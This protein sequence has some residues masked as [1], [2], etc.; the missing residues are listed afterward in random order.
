MP[1]LFQK[2]QE[3][4]QLEADVDQYVNGA[5]SGPLASL[6]TSLPARFHGKDDAELVTLNTE[7][8][9]ELYRQTD[10]G[11]AAKQLEATVRS[12]VKDS[13]TVNPSRFLLSLQYA[14]QDMPKPSERKAFMQALT[15]GQL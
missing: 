14:L 12:W 6:V 4:K 13:A 15:R 10:A 3:F 7:L 8:V 5:A 9:D 1:V 2:L 11:A